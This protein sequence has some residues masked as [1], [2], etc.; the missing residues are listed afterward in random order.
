ML[1]LDSERE[2]LDLEKRSAHKRLFWT[3]AG[4]AALVFGL[5]FI[6]FTVATK[7]PSLYAGIAVNWL[8]HFMASLAQLLCKHLS[9]GGHL[10]PRSCV[11]FCCISSLIPLALFV[12]LTDVWT[13]EMIVW[14]AS[15]I[16][17][18]VV[19]AMQLHF[20]IILLSK[21]SHDLLRAFSLR[22]FASFTGDCLSFIKEKTTILSLDALPLPWGNNGT[23]L[24]IQ[25]IAR[26]SNRN[27]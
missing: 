19:A 17:F 11:V 9:T 22:V 15:T 5:L 14:N 2:A 6:S 8:C 3:I 23:T 1:R 24:P 20:L 16:L 27:P 4:V 12:V 21:L 25:A 10:E 7:R 26:K 13:V 18:V